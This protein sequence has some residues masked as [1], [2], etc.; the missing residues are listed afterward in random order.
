VSDSHKRW[1]E[2]IDSQAMSRLPSGREAVE[3]DEGVRVDSF[4]T[5][6]RAF[7][8]RAGCSQNSLAKRVGLS[9]SYINRLERGER[10]A[11]TREVVEALANT[12]GLSAADRDRLTLAAGHPPSSLVALSGRDDVISLVADVLADESIP[13][14]ERNDFRQI[15][16]LVA[17]RW[18]PGA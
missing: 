11:P 14:E 13:E 12:L 4:G 17:R 7:R 15:I 18:R 5:L 16:R 6:L 9:P 1:L 8:E 10:E 3:N 2:S